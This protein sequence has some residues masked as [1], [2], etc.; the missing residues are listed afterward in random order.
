MDSDYRESV[1]VAFNR[2]LLEAIDKISEEWGI[3]SRPDIIELS[4]AEL[5]IPQ[6]TEA[7]PS[8]SGDSTEC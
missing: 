3:H 7:L 5:L 6:S 8:R 2:D 4:L 1:V